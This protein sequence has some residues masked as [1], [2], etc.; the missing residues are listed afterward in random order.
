MLSRNHSLI[1][2][3]R[4]LR[5]DPELRMKERLFVAEGRHLVQEALSKDAPVRLVLISPRMRER[6]GDR[7]LLDLIAARGLPL[8]ETKDSILESLQDARSPQP[9]LAL[10]AMPDSPLERLIDSL[11]E[12]PLL[13][14]AHDVQDPGNLG[15]I[16]RSAD[17]AG[18]SAFAITG[19]GADLYHPRTVRA[20]MG[21][22]FGLPAARGDAGPLIALLRQRGI[23]TM[24][25]SPV[26]STPHTAAALAGPVALFFGSEGEGLPGELLDSLDGTLSIPM[27]E[28]VESLSVGAAAAVVLFEA[29]RRRVPD[30]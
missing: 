20:T 4:A 25:T 24:G 10:V 15:T 12:D 17:A 26:S 13:A 30:R 22:I 5:R 9:I 2:K 11:P 1:R 28:G 8:E 3:L 16:M 21:S 14:V 7:A 18:A 29:A 23:V 6:A 19:N 27:R